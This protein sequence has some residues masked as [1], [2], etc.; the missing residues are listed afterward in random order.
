MGI[1]DGDAGVGVLVLIGGAKRDAQIGDRWDLGTDLIFAREQS[2][3]GRPARAALHAGQ[4]ARRR[5][6][7]A[8]VQLTDE[9]AATPITGGTAVLADGAARAVL[10]AAG[11]EGADSVRRSRACRTPDASRA[12]RPLPRGGAATAHHAS[13]RTPRQP[14][15]PQNGDEYRLGAALLEERL[16]ENL[17][18]PPGNPRRSP[19]QK[20]HTHVD[21]TTI[22]SPNLPI[23]GLYT[24]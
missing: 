10:P 8:C 21:C 5:C 17:N 24:L 13:C 9:V 12:A 7:H 11:A 1:R 4:P 16:V 3:A 22:P 15:Q 23:Q 18:F 20:I 19:F 6:L 14:P 2:P